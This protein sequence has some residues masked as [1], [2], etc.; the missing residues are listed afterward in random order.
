MEFLKNVGRGLGIYMWLCIGAGFI[1]ELGWIGA[2][3]AA[4]VWIVPIL[5]W[6]DHRYRPVK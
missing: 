4:I 1:I 6:L 2:G 5:A 3:I